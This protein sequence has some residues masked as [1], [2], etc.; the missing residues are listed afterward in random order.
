MFKD[1]IKSLNQ[2]L[3]AARQQ[4]EAVSRQLQT[5]QQQQSDSAARAEAAVHEA[6]E[7]RERHAEADAQAKAAAAAAGAGG[8]QLQPGPAQGTSAQQAG[9]VSAALSTGGTLHRLLLQNCDQ[10]SWANVVW[11]AAC[12]AC[13]LGASPAAPTYC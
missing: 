2:Q 13:K 10:A 6:Q 12:N 11:L 8:Q 9:G 1:Q 5:A 4:T 7:A 3:H